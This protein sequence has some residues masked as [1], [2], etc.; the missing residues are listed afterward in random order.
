MTDT[1]KILVTGGSGK[2]GRWVI[3]EL[4]Q[5]GYNV[6]NCDLRPSDQ[7]HTFQADLTDLGQVYGVLEG[8][9][10]VV[11]L[12][13]IPW[14]GEHP[15]EVVF[16]NNVMSTFNV[17]QAACVLG[18]RHIVL[19]GSESSLGFPFAFRPIVPKYLPVDED[20]P[21]LAQDAYGLSKITGEELAKGFARRD[22][23]L[24]IVTLRFSYIVPPDDYP[25]ELQ[26]AWSDSAHNSFNLWAYIDA[27]DV[28]TACRLAVEN[29]P[30]GHTPLYI[31]APDTLMREPTLDLV[32]K[33]FPE[34]GPAAAGFGERMSPLSSARAAA[35]LGFRPRYTW[36]HVISP[37]EAP[38]A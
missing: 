25:S 27:R 26:M 23:D 17:L 16:R 8:M 2:A 15:P 4:Q 19:A 33:V 10:A 12:A 11:H 3:A 38:S 35:V 34:A 32:Q 9:G 36:A 21:L 30:A 18:V 24:H 29:G 20:H 7:A 5:S 6:I 13:A 14:P 37:D 1:D 28:G 22:P 31:A